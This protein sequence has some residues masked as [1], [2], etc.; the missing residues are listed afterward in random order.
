MNCLLQVLGVKFQLCGRA[1]STLSHQATSLA[2]FLLLEE[3][4]GSGNVAPLMEHLPSLLKMVAS[5]L[6][7]LV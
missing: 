7:N 2:P 4:S 1:V 3:N 5:V 6:M